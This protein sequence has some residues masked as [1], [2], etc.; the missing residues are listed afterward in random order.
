MVCSKRRSYLEV[1]RAR[2]DGALLFKGESVDAAAESAGLETGLAKALA[3]ALEG[4]MTL[5]ELERGDMLRVIA[6]EITVLGEFSRYAGIEAVEVKRADREAKRLRVYYFRGPKSRGHYDDQGRAPYE[7]GWR[8][9]IKGAPVTSP[10]NMKRMHPVLKKIMPHTGVDFGCKAGEPV[11]A[12]SYGTVS[13][14][15]WAG[16]SGNLV[17][18]EHAGDYETSYAHLSRFEENLKVGDKVRRMQVIG[19]CGSTGRSTGPHLHFGVKKDGKFIDPQSLNLDGM[20]ILPKE[21]RAAFEATK[22]IYIPLLEKIPWPEPLPQPDPEPV[23]EAVFEP[24]EAEGEESIGGG[25]DEMA[26]PEDEGETVA[27]TPVAAAPKAKGAASPAAAPGKTDAVYLTDKE[28]L[29]MQGL[30]DD[31]EVDE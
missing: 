29:E 20:R 21:E 16:A 17:K 10:F 13:F 18:I 11:G 7:G 4:H 25:M 1:H 23:A 26:P 2:V 24:S 9:P 22:K 8:V 31:G 14:A 19:Y 3:K 15:A 5:G 12:S 6:Q 30:T 27:A 28:L